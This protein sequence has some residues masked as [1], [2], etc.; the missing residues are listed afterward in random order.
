MISMD[1]LLCQQSAT[2]S[3][4]FNSSHHAANNIH[5]HRNDKQQ[6][7]NKKKKKPSAIEG[8]LQNFADREKRKPGLGA[9]LFVQACVLTGCDY[10]ANDL[11]GVGLVNA[12]KLIRDNAY[13]KDHERF[14]RVLASFPNKVKAN[15]NVESYEEI[16]SK[17]EAVFYYH[18]VKDENGN[19]SSLNPFPVN[20]S[21]DSTNAENLSMHHSQHFPAPGRFGDKLTFLGDLK[22]VQEDPVKTKPFSIVPSNL[23]RKSNSSP[24]ARKVKRPT[25]LQHNPYY[26]K[27]SSSAEVRK[28]INPYLSNAN[29]KETASSANDYVVQ[30]NRFAQYAAKKD[31]FTNN[32][33]SSENSNAGMSKYYN[34]KDDVRFVK[35][36]FGDSTNTNVTQQ[37]THAI[38]GSYAPKNNHSSY[39]SLG[40]QVSMSST[41]GPAASAGPVAERVSQLGNDLQNSNDDS[42]AS[43]CSD[44]QESPRTFFDYGMDDSEDPAV[45]YDQEQNSSSES[46][47]NNMESDSNERDGGHKDPITS[48]SQ[49]DGMEPENSESTSLLINETDNLP[50]VRSNSQESDSSQ[51]LLPGSLPEDRNDSSGLIDLTSSFDDE[52]RA[53]DI[54]DVT[55]SKYFNL[56]QSEARRVTLETIDRGVLDDSISA[57]KTPGKASYSNQAT[58][59]QTPKGLSPWQQ[60]EII[61]SPDFVPQL[62]RATS[63]Q[64][65]ARPGPSKKGRKSK[66][67]GKST[68]LS[69]FQRQ[70]E[71]SS[72]QNSTGAFRYTNAPSIDWS[73]GKPRKRGRKSAGLTQLQLFVKEKDDGF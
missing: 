60:D 47:D 40:G 54:Q 69:A 59:T 73:D 65:A 9:R 42:N 18:L 62:K 13:R 28:I 24:V 68:I 26:V 23:A 41:T 3:Y 29:K 12:F 15:L 31:G 50:G 61:E 21:D 51:E 39:F 44:P 46:Q 37:R 71:L 5:R 33:V 30:N 7:N 4:T 67:S 27:E 20:A 36:K 53:G 72:S 11:P 22:S 48:Q 43:I 45:E 25:L 32:N 58:K 17:S 57:P 66:K 14:Q 6:N 38:R 64:V 8:L 1:W 70:Q 56:K 2:P 35:R 19:V 52:A 10:A 34:A 55:A 16:L 63:T 49:Q